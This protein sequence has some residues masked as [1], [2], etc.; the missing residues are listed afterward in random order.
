M[1]EE[2]S[3]QFNRSKSRRYQGKETG[4]FEVV[5]GGKAVCPGPWATSIPSWLLILIPS[6][7]QMAFVNP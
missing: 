4:S 7:L 1:D 6:F 5:C 2:D 3:P